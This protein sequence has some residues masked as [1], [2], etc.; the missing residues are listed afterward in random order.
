M[1]LPKCGG[2]TFATI[3][4]RVYPSQETFTI[5]VI[6]NTKL[7]T[8]EFINLPEEKRDKINL[9]KGHLEFGLHEYMSGKTDYITFMRDPIERVIS[10]YY[11]VKRK[12]HHKLYQRNLFK[13]G[14]SLYEFVTQ[15]KQADINNGQIRFLSGIQDTEEHMLEKAL[16]NIE[17]HFSFVGTTEKFD[18]SLAILQKMYQWKTPYYSVENKTNN[19][20]LT[21]DIDA[22]TLEAIE[23]HNAGDIAV[24]N[25]ITKELNDRISS[26]T[27]LTEAIKR[28]HF[29]NRI[30]KFLPLSM[31][32]PLIK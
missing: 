28:I 20:P 32:S 19:R 13:D 27:S 6:D 2:T 3:L 12:P 1:H 14:M 18:E 24:Y 31:I 15:I 29:Y 11:Y 5:K 23:H 8:E 21:H 9:L 10:Y 22:K 7:N 26:D 4:E 17:N 30:N 16:E 25:K